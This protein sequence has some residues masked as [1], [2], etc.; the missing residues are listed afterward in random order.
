MPHFLVAFLTLGCAAPLLAADKPPVYLWLEPEW[1][2][3]VSGSFG[4]WTGEAKPT[5]AWGVARVDRR[6][7]VDVVLKTTLTVKSVKEWTEPRELK[8]T[9]GEVRVRVPA[10]DV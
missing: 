4:Y 8:V 2:D 1:F 9:N 10:G 6:Q 3:V 5:G 7:F